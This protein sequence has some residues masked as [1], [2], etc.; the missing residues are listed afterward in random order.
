LTLQ[1]KIKNLEQKSESC[2][3]PNGLWPPPEN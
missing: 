2:E 1:L 3:E